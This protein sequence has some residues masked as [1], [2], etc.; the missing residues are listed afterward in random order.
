[1]CISF[2][3]AQSFS[4]RD[5]SVV[6]SFATLRGASCLHSSGLRCSCC[7]VERFCCDLEACNLVTDAFVCLVNFKVFA[8]SPYA[9]TYLE[10]SLPYLEI[11]LDISFVKSFLFENGCLL[12]CNTM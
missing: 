10:L 1:M 12:G 11:L 4:A 2:S 5:R 7:N 8:F 9:S 6:A 3:V